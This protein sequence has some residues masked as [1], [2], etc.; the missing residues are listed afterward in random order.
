MQK[1]EEVVIDAPIKSLPLDCFCECK[2]LKRV[3]LPQGLVYI[4]S[5]AF[6]GCS[7][8]EKII[9]PD[10]CKKIGEWSFGRCTN[11]K[12]VVISPDAIIEKFAFRSCPC[13]NEEVTWQSVTAKAYFGEEG[14]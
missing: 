10:S 4:P 6:Y 9:L 3:T 1:L 13:E 8:L 2:N 14:T 5:N 12:E 7:S 11:L